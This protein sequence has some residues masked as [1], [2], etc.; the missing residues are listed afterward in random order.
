MRTDQRKS[1]PVTFSLLLI[2]IEAAYILF[3][4]LLLVGLQ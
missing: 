1:S 4:P 2:E 3:S